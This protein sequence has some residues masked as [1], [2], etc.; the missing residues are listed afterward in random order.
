[1]AGKLTTHV[2]DTV[3][4]LGAAAMRLSWRRVSPHPTKSYEA[5]LDGSGRGTL[6]PG[7]ELI[8]GVYEIVFAVGEYHRN[9]ALLPTEQ[10][11]LDEVPVRFGIA[12]ADAHCHIP[13]VVS[14]FGYS[15]HRGG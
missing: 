13:L 8:P 9:L 14:P 3:L 10:P 2:V 7:P 11:F 1:M 15:I 6:I 4:G 5:Q 12:D